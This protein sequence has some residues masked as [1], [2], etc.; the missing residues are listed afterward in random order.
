[1]PFKDFR[2]FLELLEKA[3]LLYSLDREVDKDWELSAIARWVYTGF[4]EEERFA[5]KFQRVKGHF[6][7]GGGGCHRGLL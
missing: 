2:E 7:A 5:L 6:Y 1:M 4:P 3:G